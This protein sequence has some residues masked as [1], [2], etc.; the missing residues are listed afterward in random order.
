MSTFINKSDEYPSKRRL[1]AWFNNK[2]L[3]LKLNLKINTKIK[4]I[5]AGLI[6]GLI[7]FN[8]FYP[9]HIDANFQNNNF[10]SKNKTALLLNE[11]ILEIKNYNSTLS[12]EQNLINHQNDNEIKLLPLKIALKQKENYEK[13]YL[14][15]TAYSSSPDET[16][17]DPF[18][19]AS[20]TLVR[21]GI[22]ATNVLPFKTKIKIPKLFGDK[23]FTVEDRMH[24]RKTNIV[25]VWME[26]KEK[27]LNFGAHYVEVFILKNQEEFAQK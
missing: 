23:I 6:L 9:K 25:D 15:V 12:T 2:N 21:D 14:W 11:N 20:N 19:T 16:D 13:I 10:D 22:V 26:S 1:W 7:V 17:A 27:A 4:K 24:Q 8:G 18:I 5:L 3:I